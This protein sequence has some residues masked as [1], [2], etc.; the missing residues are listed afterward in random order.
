MAQ[1]ELKKTIVEFAKTYEYSN[2]IT[3]D[4][5]GFPKGRMM[6][7]LPFGE[8]LIFWFA[9]GAQSNKV[10]EIKKNSKTSVFLYRPEDHASISVA[11]NAEIVTDDDVR[12][13]KWNEKWSAFW[14]KGSS[15]PEYTLIK[16]VPKQIVY[17]DF[18]NHNQEILELQEC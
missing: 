1:E 8:D 16:I 3:I 13:E 5:S 10:A 12:N 4:G 2:L 14:E 15:D 17:L 9:T 7:N 6:E 18:A 11:G